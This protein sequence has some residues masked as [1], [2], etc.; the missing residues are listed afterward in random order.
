MLLKLVVL[1]DMIN[2]LYLQVKLI[3]LKIKQEEIVYGIIM[4]VQIELVIKQIKH[5]QL[6]MLVNHTVLNVQLM[7]RD[8]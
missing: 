2:V 1:R 3:V 7:E 4:L 6:M 8:A 5:L